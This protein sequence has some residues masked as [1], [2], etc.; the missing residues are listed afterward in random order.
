VAFALVMMFVTGLLLRR[1][2]V[3]EPAGQAGPAALELRKALANRNIWLLA[4]EF[5]CFNLAM[6]ALGT[7]YPTFLNEVHGYPLGQAAFLASLGTMTVLV[8]A[9]L[10][11]WLSDRIGSRRLVFSIPFL[12]AA[13]L[14]IFPFRVTGWMI[15]AIQIALGM[16]TGAIPT[17][18][19]AAAPEIMHRPQ[20]AGLGLAAVLV[21]QNLGQLVGPV[22]FGQL[23]NNLGWVTAGYFLIPVCLAGFISGWM[24]KVR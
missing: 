12:A 6:V 7:Y 21:G 2:P 23:V 15:P 10:A 14:F 1:P 5:A 22:L 3:E 20:W 17:A 16:L 18:T 19:F 8:S 11:G 24:V 9:P 13:V 4:L